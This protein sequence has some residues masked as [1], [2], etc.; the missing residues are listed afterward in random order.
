MKSETPVRG[1]FLRLWDYVYTGTVAMLVGAGFYRLATDPD[2][3]VALVH[4]IAIAML[5]GA[6]RTLWKNESDNS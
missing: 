2:P 6:L 5:A 4:G 1:F 3:L